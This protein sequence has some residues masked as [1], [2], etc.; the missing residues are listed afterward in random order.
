M[1]IK[2]Q[3]AYES[4]NFMRLFEF[5][6]S[7]MFWGLPNTVRFCQ[8][9][10]VGG[11]IGWKNSSMYDAIFLERLERIIRNGLPA[12]SLPAETEISLLNLSENATWLLREPQSGRRRVLRMHRPGYHAD[13]EIRSELA[14]IGALSASGAFE[15][16]LP[17]AGRN[18]EL[19]QALP[20]DAGVRQAVL[21]EHVEGVEPAPGADL[22]DWFQRLGA[23]TASL[24][25]HARAWPRPKAF[26]RKTWDFDSMLGSRS[27]WGDWRLAVGL[28]SRGEALL[29][30]A[31]DEI[32]RRLTVYGK[33]PDRFGLIH[34]DLRPA[35]LLVSGDRLNVIDFDDSG[36]GWFMYDFAAAV[37]FFEA[38][39]V[40]PQLA[41]RWLDGYRSV[42]PL[43]A[44]DEAMLPTFIL[45]R[46]IL[47]LAW[48]STH[49]ETPTG[50]AHGQ[51]YTD[52]ALALAE[53]YLTQP[54]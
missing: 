33:S 51:F 23:V 11:S 31:A 25:R 48:V 52:G 9:C 39:P 46:R 26:A 19:L 14:W 45:L 49:R 50:E 20:D 8:I 37:S 53:S 15:T 29:Q 16:P 17:M 43:S 21:F 2:Q 4:I 28:D 35:T 1:L 18:R 13:D 41:G 6:A 34:A 10:P 32:E 38:D 54:L 7:N 36:Y 22:P 30:R 3:Y 24:Q 5:C 42:A 27:I 12:W 47:L 40:V 44:E